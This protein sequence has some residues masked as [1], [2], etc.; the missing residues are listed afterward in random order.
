VARRRASKTQAVTN[1]NV[2][3]QAEK[4]D[5]AEINTLILSIFCGEYFVCGE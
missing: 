5:S 2:T 1:I 4:K 3:H